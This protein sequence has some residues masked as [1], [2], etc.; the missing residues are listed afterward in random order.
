MRPPRSSLSSLMYA[1]RME[2]FQPGDLV[3]L[4]SGSPDMTV[5]ST[6]KIARNDAHLFM[7]MR[8]VKR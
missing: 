5:E 7:E 8:R 1:V 3:V 6:G 4:R 2:N